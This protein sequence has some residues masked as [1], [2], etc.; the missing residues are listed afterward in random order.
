MQGHSWGS[1]KG[2]RNLGERARGIIWD[3]SIGILV[4]FSNIRP[5]YLSMGFEIGLVVHGKHGHLSLL[6]HF[7][8][9]FTTHEMT[10]N[11]HGHRE[12][13]G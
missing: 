4:K 9:T 10:H 7:S 5:R 3:L 11:V 13:N 12:D 2:E 6:V 8:T 1:I